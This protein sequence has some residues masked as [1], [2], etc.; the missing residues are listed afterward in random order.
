MSALT[1]TCLPL[2]CPSFWVLLYQHSVKNIEK[3]EIKGVQKRPL[4]TKSCRCVGEPAEAAACFR[5]GGNW[6][7]FFTPGRSVSQTGTCQSLFFSLGN[8]S[9]EFCVLSIAMIHALYDVS[10]NTPCLL[11]ALPC[12]HYLISI[13][14]GQ[15]IQAR[16]LPLHISKQILAPLERACFEWT[17]NRDLPRTRARNPSSSEFFLCVYLQDIPEPSLQKRLWLRCFDSQ[18]L[19]H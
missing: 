11:E 14:R 4:S 8:L 12:T 17:V 7:A 10:Q 6:E 9:R 16:V 19:C 18:S 1:P 5:A 13:I 3:K 15:W 2:L